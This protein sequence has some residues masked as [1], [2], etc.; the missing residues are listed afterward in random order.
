MTRILRH[1]T[2]SS[3]LMRANWFNQSICGNRISTERQI[4]NF[5]LHYWE[6]N[7]PFPDPMDTRWHLSLLQCVH[8]RRMV[9]QQGLRLSI[10][11]HHYHLIHWGG[12][13][14]QGWGL[15]WRKMWSSGDLWKHRSAPDLMQC[16]CTCRCCR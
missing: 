3:R 5:N 12:T 1:L 6:S 11:K 8:S 13:Y 10:C 15:S 14:H 16:S 2:T 4:C 7:T 9:G